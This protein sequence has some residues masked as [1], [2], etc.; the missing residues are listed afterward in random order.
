MS[1]VPAGACRYMKMGR[2][3][4]DSGWYKHPLCTE[5]S[6]CH[7][8]FFFIYFRI[9]TGSKMLEPGD[10]NLKTAGEKY[11]KKQ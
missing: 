11:K 6:S 4:C 2:C 3:S 9:K 5:V 8:F 7:S 1:A 10:K